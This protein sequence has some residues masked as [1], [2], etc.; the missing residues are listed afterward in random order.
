MA[1]RALEIFGE[2][3]TLLDGPHR[4]VRDV[5]RVSVAHLETLL[6]VLRHLDD[7]VADRLLPGLRSLEFEVH[8]AGDL[9]LRHHAD[10]LDL[11]PALRDG[12]RGEIFSGGFDLLGSRLSR[13]SGHG[14]D[15]GLAWIRAPSQA[16]L[17]IFHLLSE[18]GNGKTCRRRVLGATATIREMAEA[19]RAHGL[20]TLADDVRHWA[21]ILRMPIRSRRD[22]AQLRASQPHAAAF[23]MQDRTVLCRRLCR[24]RAGLCGRG[25]RHDAP[26]PL[27]KIRRHRSGRRS[28][29]LRERIAGQR[30]ERK[31]DQS[32][33][34]FSHTLSFKHRVSVSKR[35]YPS[36][37][38]QKTAL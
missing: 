24:S 33:M 15:V 7:A 3:L 32:E 36:T 13:E 16:V 9:R 18:V 17:E 8:V 11:D 31:C 28:G 30:Y 10:F 14:V 34:D 26:R 27:G 21:V 20:T 12:Q 22:A 37:Q 19:A 29:L 25:R 4:H 35:S 38:R 23:D 2:R 6:A 5:A 1:E